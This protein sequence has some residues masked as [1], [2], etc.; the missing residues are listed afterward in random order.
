MGS[1]A[2]KGIA[3]GCKVLATTLQEDVLQSPTMPN[4]RR[5][6]EDEWRY[7]L[8][9]HRIHEGLFARVAKQRGIDC[10]YVSRVAKGERTSER[11][12]N[13]IVTELRRIE[14]L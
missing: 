9:K 3:D 2:H 8:R 10:S 5:A 12:L 7:L 14:R 4:S 1:P 6:G 11:I 13:A